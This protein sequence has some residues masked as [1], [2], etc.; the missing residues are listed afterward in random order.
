MNSI[1][2][3]SIWLHVKLSKGI[4][5][6]FVLR[7]PPLYKSRSGMCCSEAGF[8]ISYNFCSSTPYE[9]DI[10]RCTFKGVHNRFHLFLSLFFYPVNICSLSFGLKTVLSLETYKAQ[11]C[12][13]F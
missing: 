6:N 2:S 4:M 9:A 13:P 3:I 12:N 7:E 5:H 8:I 11:Q 10:F 1:V